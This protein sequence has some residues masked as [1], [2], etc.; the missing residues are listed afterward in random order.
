VLPHRRA[1]DTP[2]QAFHLLHRLL[3]HL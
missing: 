3:T 2:R 1:V